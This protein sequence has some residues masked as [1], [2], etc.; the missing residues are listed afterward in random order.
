MA[1]ARALELEM[2]A[3]KHAKLEQVMA[4]FEQQLQK[5][6]EAEETRLRDCLEETFTKDVN[7]LEADKN[8]SV[9]EIEQL[10]RQLTEQ[11]SFFKMVL[12]EL[13]GKK[14]EVNNSYQAS[15]QYLRTE[16]ASQ[17]EQQRKKMQK[18]LEQKTAI[19]RK[20]QQTLN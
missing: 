1:R 3:I 7:R 11:I 9:H 4:Q 13:E 8:A 14:Q 17:F 19:F 10:Q 20:Y 15:V 12:T 18:H 2:E 16:M 6:A 5:D